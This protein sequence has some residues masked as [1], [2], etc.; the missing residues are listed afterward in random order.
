MST[1]AA[2]FG[3]CFQ[4]QSPTE[5][6]VKSRQGTTFPI[7]SSIFCTASRRFCSLSPRL[8]PSPTYTSA[9]IC[10]KSALH[11]H[12]Y[13]NGNLLS[14][15]RDKRPLPARI[16][17]SGYNHQECR[18]RHMK[19]GNHRVSHSKFVRR[20]DELICQPSNSFK[21]PSVLTALSIARITVVPTAH[22]FLPVSLARLTVSPPLRPQASVPS[23][24]CASSSLLHQCPEVAQAGM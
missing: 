9:I 16:R 24:F 22:T 23:P 1:Q 21:C 10:P 19:I 18:K 12:K 20:E 13:R 2:A 8:V 6:N 15:L 5:R 14:M 3:N 17:R 4:K 11:R 7:C